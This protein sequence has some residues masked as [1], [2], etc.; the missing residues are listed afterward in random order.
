MSSGHW[1]LNTD[2]ISVVIVPAH[3]STFLLLRVHRVH[4]VQGSSLVQANVTPEWPRPSLKLNTSWL[5]R[6]LVLVLARPGSVTPPHLRGG[7]AG[8]GRW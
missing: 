2:W 6:W 8:A 3:L 5:L 7:A 4:R 1:T